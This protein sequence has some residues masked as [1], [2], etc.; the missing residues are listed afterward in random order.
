MALQQDVTITGGI[1]VPTAYHRIVIVN[2]NVELQN[3]DIFVKIYKDQ[4]SRQN[5]IDPVTSKTYH[6]DGTNFT[7]YLTSDDCNPLDRNHVYQ[8]Y[9]YLKT[10][11]DYVGAIDV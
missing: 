6:I 11:P 4:T 7:T 3:A 8:T 2:I 1:D 5:G 10:L 9:E